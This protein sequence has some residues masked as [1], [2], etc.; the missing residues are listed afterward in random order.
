VT[1]ALC[2]RTGVAGGELDPADEGKH[3]PGAT[4]DAA[5]RAEARTLKASLS[6]Q[7]NRSRVQTASQ[8]DAGCTQIGAAG[9][10]AA[11]S[12]RRRPFLLH[13]LS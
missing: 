13:Q 2:S 10:V 3:R 7:L 1:H 12:R 5:D 8:T 6:V 9:A 11:R 4:G